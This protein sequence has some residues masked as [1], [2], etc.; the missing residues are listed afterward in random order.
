MA[1]EKMKCGHCGTE[2]WV[3]PFTTTSCKK[4]GHPIK[5]TKSK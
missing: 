2:N 3:N 1:Q 5:G 4:C